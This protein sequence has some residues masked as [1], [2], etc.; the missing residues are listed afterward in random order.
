MMQEIRIGSTVKLKSG[1][2]KMVVE[3]I[4]ETVEHKVVIRIAH[5]VW[6]NEET[7]C[8]SRLHVS[9]DGLVDASPKDYTFTEIM[10]DT[11]NVPFR[12]RLCNSTGELDFITH[13]TYNTYVVSLSESITDKINHQLQLNPRE[14]N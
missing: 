4:V 5:C 13:G 9:V 11:C 10:Y 8:H 3:K 2:P 6:W 14:S 7:K 12:A 1:G